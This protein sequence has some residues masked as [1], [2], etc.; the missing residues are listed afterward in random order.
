MQF[1][2]FLAPIFGIIMEWLYKLV[3]SYG[4]TLIIFTVI[5]KLL[6]FPLSVKQQ[7][8][9]ARMSA[10][11]PMIQEIQK[12]WANDKQ[13]QQEELM[14]FQE[15]T[16]M[17]MTAGCMPMLLNFL[18]LFGIIEVVYRPLQYILRVPKDLIT[19]AVDVANSA[20]GMNLTAANYTVQNTLINAVK[21]SPN[22][23]SSVFSAE[24][25]SAISSFNFHFMGLD[26]SQVPRFAFDAASLALMVIPLLSAVTMILSQIIVMK[27][28]GQEAQ[29]AMKWMPWFMSLWFVWIGF[30]IPVGFSLYYT[31]SNVLM[32]VQSVILK[33][34][35]DPE[36]MKLQVQEEIAAKR[37]EKKKKKQVRVVA[38]DGSEKMKEVS[39]AE[40]ARIRLARAREIDEQRYKEE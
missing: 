6:M 8:S 21:E 12:K 22:A 26:L 39:E 28:S 9:T 25:I 31:V 13:R 20:L 40:L 1:L 33:K 36:Q 7:K 2:G 5:T 27:M 15:E 16:G 3:P 30:T 17:S 19:Q 18:V 4:W 34:I 24:Q 29:G 23:F 10:Y 37:A 11:Q 35:Y 14:K 32:L 38:E